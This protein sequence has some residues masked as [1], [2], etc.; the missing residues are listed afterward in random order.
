MFWPPKHPASN[1]LSEN[2][3]QPHIC[4]RRQILQFHYNIGFLIFVSIQKHTIQHPGELFLVRTPRS[5]VTVLK[6]SLQIKIHDRQEQE[7]VHHDGWGS[8]PGHLSQCD[9]YQ[10]V[11]TSNTKEGREKWIS[12]IVMKVLRPLTHIVRLPRNIRCVVHMEHMIPWNDI[13]SGSP[14][15][16][17][18]SF[19]SREILPVNAGQERNELFIPVEPT[20]LPFVGGPKIFRHLLYR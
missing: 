10:P 19:I 14:V 16:L 18:N 5:R 17:P 1:G 20:R 4:K 15:H 2:N 6:P 11:T 12:R 13:L 9:M 8:R 3:V 7:E